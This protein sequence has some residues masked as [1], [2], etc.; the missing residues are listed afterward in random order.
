MGTNYYS[1]KRGIENLDPDEFWELKNK[2][3]MGESDDV[4]HIGKSSMGWCF[5]LH[6]I[7]ERGIHDLDD[8]IPV[9]IDPWRIM[10][11]EYM[12]LV[13]LTKIMG[14][15]TARRGREDSRW[16]AEDYESNY[17]EPGPSNLVRHTVGMG[18]VKHGEG[19]WDCITGDFS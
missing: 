12:R 10:I 6:I 14:T 17:A 19:T 11:D 8:W 15:I 16:T 3:A 13:D 9:F 18:C 7:P 2:S 4:L 5:S 1:V